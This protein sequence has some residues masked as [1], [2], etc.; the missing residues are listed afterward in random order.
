MM[1]KEQ[2][3]WGVFAARLVCAAELLT[4]LMKT[5]AALALR[6]LEELEMEALAF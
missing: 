3:F 4:M 1:G 2:V 5:D 6:E